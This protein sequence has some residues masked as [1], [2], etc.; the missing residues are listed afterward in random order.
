[1]A[2]RNWLGVTWLTL[3]LIAGQ[4]AGQLPVEGSMPPPVVNGF[5]APA[6]GPPPGPP[7]MASR[8]PGNALIPGSPYAP[9]PAGYTPPTP[10][11]LPASR[12]P[13][14]NRLGMCCW[15]DHNQ[16]TCSSLQSELIFIFGSCRCFFGERCNQGPHALPVP[17]GLGYRSVYP[18]P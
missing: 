9:P 2:A 10:V 17:N 5:E 1:M 6:F 16:F 14:L 4:A 15:T 3:L 11:S 12:H 7:P 13:C 18:P 8:F